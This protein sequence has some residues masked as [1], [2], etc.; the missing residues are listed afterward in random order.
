MHKYFFASYGS[1]H[2]FKA[3]FYLQ[4]QIVRTNLKCEYFT[5]SIVYVRPLFKKILDSHPC[6]ILFFT[7]FQFFLKIFNMF[8]EKYNPIFKFLK[9]FH[10]LLIQTRY[11]SRYLVTFSLKIQVFHWFLFHMVSNLIKI[12][13]SVAEETIFTLIELF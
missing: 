4:P 3:S 8:Y 7:S 5:T 10:V 6:P 9:I 11:N 12:G 2:Q 1:F 13:I